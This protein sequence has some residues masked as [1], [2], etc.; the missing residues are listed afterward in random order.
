MDAGLFW[1]CRQWTR[2]HTDSG[3][4]AVSHKYGQ[5]PLVVHVGQMPTVL[6]CRRPLCLDVNVSQCQES[7]DR[8]ETFSSVSLRRRKWA[9]PRLLQQALSYTLRTGAQGS[10]RTI[11]IISW[12]KKRRAIDASCTRYNADSFTSSRNVT[13]CRNRN[14][15]NSACRNSACRNRNCLPPN[16]TF[17]Q[18]RTKLES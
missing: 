10:A 12:T 13:T 18:T 9:L 11:L 1:K 14:F 4:V 2:C 6:P 7:G 8:R 16:L 15:R 17:P 3:C 5:S